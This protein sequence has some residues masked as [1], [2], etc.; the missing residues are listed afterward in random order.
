VVEHAQR[1]ERPYPWLTVTVAAF[2]LALVGVALVVGLE[3]NRLLHTHRATAQARG[4]APPP[5]QRHATPSLPLR[6]RSRVS[7]LVLN[8]NGLSGVAGATATRL[9]DRGYRSATP[10]NAPSR[11][12]AISLVLYRPGWEREAQRLGRDAGIRVVSPLD[13][14]LPAHAGRDQLILILGAN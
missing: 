12:Y 9:V 13:G 1:L 8:G 6:S 4:E 14:Q 5:V 10:T 2:V 11:D 3:A 7:V